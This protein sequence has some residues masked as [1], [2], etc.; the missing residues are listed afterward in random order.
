MHLNGTSKLED[1]IIVDF[2]TLSNQLSNEE[3][4]P[5]VSSDMPW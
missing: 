4:I 5:S 3:N 2:D 1:N